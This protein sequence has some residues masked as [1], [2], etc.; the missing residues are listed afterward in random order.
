VIVR[1]VEAVDLY[2]FDLMQRTPDPPPWVVEV[3]D[4]IFRHAWY[5]A[6]QGTER[7]FLL[8]E[9]DNGELIGVSACELASDG[10]AYLPAVLVV[11]E[12]RRQGYARQLLDETLDR[13]ELLAPGGTA[14]W[15]VHE[16]NA[17]M[18]RLSEETGALATGRT[19]DAYLR[20]ELAF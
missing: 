18:R 14:F 11:Y 16:D 10:V 19:E 20:F 8:A 5:W 17:V 4:F 15:L 6:N 9:D 3:E 12:Q 13:A 2:R 1:K 7:A